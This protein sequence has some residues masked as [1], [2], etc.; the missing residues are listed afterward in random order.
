MHLDEYAQ[1][2]ED[3]LAVVEKEWG[4]LVPYMRKMQPLKKKRATNSRHAYY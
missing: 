3:Q 2:F 4:K 1:N